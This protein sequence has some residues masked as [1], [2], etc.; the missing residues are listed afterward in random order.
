MKKFAVDWVTL[1]ASSVWGY[2]A[3]A[4]SN[5]FFCHII[6][7][8]SYIYSQNKNEELMS[9]KWCVTCKANLWSPLDSIGL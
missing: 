2:F 9:R 7:K 1:M 4:H 5:A 3:D 6:C 8:V